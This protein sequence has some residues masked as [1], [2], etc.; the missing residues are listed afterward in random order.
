MTIKEI[1]VRLMEIIQYVSDLP[2]HRS[3]PVEFR[4]AIKD[5][6]RQMYDPQARG[7]QLDSIEE[8]LVQNL[9][10]TII[11]ASQLGINLENETNAIL[12]KIETAAL[13][14]C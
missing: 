7:D 8:N 6:A 14:C 2:L 9:I 13:P 12:M 11:I 3:L 4:E 5:Y 1:Q 10:N